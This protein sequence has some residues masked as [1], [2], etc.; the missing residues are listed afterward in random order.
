MSTD[1]I[2]HRSC[3]LCGVWM[4]VR[5]ADRKGAAN[6]TFECA[7]CRTVIHVPREGEKPQETPAE[8]AHGPR[9]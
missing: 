2:G 8:A 5:K 4:V 1:D 6:D 7:L 3:P 9:A